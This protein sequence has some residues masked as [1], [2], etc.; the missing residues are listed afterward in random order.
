MNSLDPPIVVKVS[1]SLYDLP[2]LGPKLQTWLKT[3]NTMNVLLVPGGGA[4]ADVIRLFDRVHHLGDEAAHWL[5]LRSLTLNAHLLLRLL[6]TAQLIGGTDRELS[7]EGRDRWAIVD[8]HAFAEAD[9]HREGKL[10]HIWEVTSDAVAARVAVVS[11]SRRLVLLKSAT[12]PADMNL[13]TAV[14]KGYIDPVLPGVLTRG[15]GKVAVEFVN[16]RLWT[17]PAADAP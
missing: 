8:A 9:E 3:L 13:W 17:A 15:G 16:L 5:A 4:T 6:P 12:V 10:P 1:G 14:E 2:D 7:Q 11:G